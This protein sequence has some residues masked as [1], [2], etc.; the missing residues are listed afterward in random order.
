MPIPSRKKDEDRSSFMS[1]CM[2]D[3]KMGEE[4]PDQS[5]RVAICMSKACEGMDYVQAADFKMYFESYGSEE[6][7][8]EDNFHIPS[9][10]DYVSS[11]EVYYEDNE[12]EEWDVAASK[13]G[14]WENIRKKKEREGKNYK[15]AKPGDPDRPD[16]K[17]WKKAQSIL[18]KAIS[19]YGEGQMQREQL[20]KMHEQLMEIEEYLEGI[21]FEEWTKDMISK[22]EIYIQNIYD[23]IEANK[24]EVEDEEDDEEDDTEAKFKYEDPKTGEIYNY[25]RQGIYKK[26]GRVLVPVNA[27]EYQGRKVQLGKPFRTPKGPKKFS[28]YVKNDKGN[29]VKVNF[30]DPNM[31]IKKNIPERRKSF[32]ARH[33]CDNPGPRWK[34]RYWS[35]R[36]W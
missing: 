27:S 3:N 24:I 21:V 28:V 25:K 10:A 9:Q 12:I 33:N 1:R 4:Y 5:Q 13:P 8:T 17:S 2:G 18:R 32:R 11:D 22:A 19:E 7:L 15:P 16:P 36:A 14:L 6:E 31:K 30:G 34:A 23:F 26:D 29:V 35:C 20:M